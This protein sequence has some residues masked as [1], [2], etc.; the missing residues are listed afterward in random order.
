MLITPTSKQK[1]ALE[2]K[3]CRKKFLSGKLGQRKILRGSLMKN[4]AI[5]GA[6]QRKFCGVFVLSK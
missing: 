5:Y 2:L 3:G 6:S 4:E 1:A